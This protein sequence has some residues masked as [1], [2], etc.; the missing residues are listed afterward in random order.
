MKCLT[1]FP[2][3][4]KQTEQPI[5]VELNPKNAGGFEIQ[6]VLPRLDSYTELSLQKET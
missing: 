6:A 3:T 1:A 5:C 4:N 2:K